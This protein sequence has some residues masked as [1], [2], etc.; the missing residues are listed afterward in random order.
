MK[1]IKSRLPDINGPFWGAWLSMSG[2]GI[3]TF[4]PALAF[5]REWWSEMET[6]SE[7]LN[8]HKFFIKS[9]KI[10]DER[11]VHYFIKG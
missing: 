11:M 8:Q 2:Q 1:Q 5:I 4:G 3:S 10:M 6:F 7:R 9:L